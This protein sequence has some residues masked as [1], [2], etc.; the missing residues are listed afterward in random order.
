MR[1][2]DD[3]AALRFVVVDP[4]P[5]QSQLGHEDARLCH[6]PDKMAR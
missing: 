4:Q 2:D 3:L 1:A 5:L 6:V